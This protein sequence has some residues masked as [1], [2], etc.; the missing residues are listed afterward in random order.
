MTSSIPTPEPDDAPTSQQ[1]A[2]PAAD[3]TIPDAPAAARR[4]R[5]PWITAGT[6]ALVLAGGGAVAAT[7]H[8]SVELDVAGATSHVGAFGGT[9]GD[10]LASK[11]ISLGE[12]DVV[13]PGAST[14]LRDGQEIVVRYGSRVT[15]D[16]DG[17]QT[18]VWTTALDAQG[19][20]DALASRGKDVSLVASRSQARTPLELPLHAD[21][22]VKVVAD[23]TTRTVQDGSVGVDGVLTEL[24]ISPD[25][26]DQVLVRTGADG[27]TV[28][29]K[30]VQVKKVT[31]TSP[32][33]YKT[34]T[35]KDPS[36]YDDLPT[37]VRTAGKKG[38]RSVVTRV[39]T[40]DGTVTDKERL[41][42]K[43][44]TKP[45]DRVLVKGTKERPAPE[46]VAAA[47]PS[48]SSAS[49]SSKSSSSSSSSSKSSSSKSSKSSSASSGA[50]SSGGGSAPSGVWAALAKCESGGNPKAVNPAGYY[51]LYQFTPQTWRAMGGS[52]LPTD[53]SAAVQTAMAKKLQARSGWGQWP[54][55]SAKLGLR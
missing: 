40:V 44:T 29:V 34:T 46:P 2:V 41:S 54:A 20:L 51:G 24:G 45:V 36:R 5:W 26:D 28:I 25:A 6:L 8:K 16:V 15:A 35:T 53:A 33:G 27:V 39:T 22:P 37:V 10:L 12:H 55:C 18:T 52:G 19:A 31:T 17:K 50:S 30:D 1:P 13:S 7:V 49:S 9:V 43:V 3:V 47:A 42:A 38:E 21:G 32:V 23:G 48:T 11:G 4:R 14:P